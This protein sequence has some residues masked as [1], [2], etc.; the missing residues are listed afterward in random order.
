M[1]FKKAQLC[2][3]LGLLSVVQTAPAARERTRGE[4]TP[5]PAYQWRGC[6]LDVSRHYFPMSYLRQQ[7]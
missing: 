1:R 4:K 7:V 2:A 6:M 5:Q 3:L